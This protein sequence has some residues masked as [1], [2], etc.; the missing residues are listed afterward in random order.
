MAA[1]T[2]PLTP[3][4]EPGRHVRPAARG[5]G[6]SYFHRRTPGVSP[7]SRAGA[8]R[9]RDLRE[10]CLTRLRGDRIASARAATLAG[11]RATA[12]AHAGLAASARRNPDTVHRAGRSHPP[13]T[14]PGGRVS[15]ARPAAGEPSTTRRHGMRLPRAAAALAGSLALVAGGVAGAG[16]IARAAATS[17]AG[18]TAA[19]PA[20]AAAPAVEH[21]SRLLAHQRQPDPRLGREPGPDRRHQLVRLRDSR[22]DRARPLGAGLPR[23]HQRHQEPRLQHDPDPVF[24]PDGGDPDRPAEPQLL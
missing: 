10:Q 9:D 4:R 11:A 7:P 19:R 2:R 8:G 18:T 5:S 15:P 17:T 22:R 23:D 13:D 3:Y 16:A 20:A 14:I 1:R 21:R 24:Q 6:F 12:S